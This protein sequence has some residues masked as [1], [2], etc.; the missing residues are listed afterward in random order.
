MSSRRAGSLSSAARRL[1]F[2]RGDETQAA[3]A[4]RVGISRSSLANYE[5]GRS[6]PND[7]TLSKIAESTG[8]P[9]D[10]F[11]SNADA[12]GQSMAAT[13]GKIVEGVPDWTQDEATLVRV[14]RLCDQ[15]TVKEVLKVVTEGAGRGEFLVNMRTIFTVKDDLQRLLD[16]AAGRRAD[17]KG[18]V[19]T[20]PDRAPL[21]HIGF[22]E[23]PPKGPLESNQKQNQ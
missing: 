3:F 14:L 18:A 19:A 21:H 16:L 17:D 20:D 11:T 4:K 6:R 12:F 13:L 23:H 5:T 7:F 9:V 2:L 8:T 1:R 15:A 22:K 10:Y